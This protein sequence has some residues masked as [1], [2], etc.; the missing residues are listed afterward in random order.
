[1]VRRQRLG[2]SRNI[3]L[4]KR[5]DIVYLQFCVKKLY[6]FPDLKI[7][8][9]AIKVRFA[10]MELEMCQSTEKR[11]AKYGFLINMVN[12]QILTFSQSCH[13]SRSSPG[14]PSDIIFNFSVS[15]EKV[16]SFDNF[17]FR[18][19]CTITIPA[20]H[21]RQCKSSLTNIVA[22]TPFFKW[23][24]NSVRLCGSG[25]QISGYQLI[26]MADFDIFYF[27]QPILS[28]MRLKISH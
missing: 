23:P 9:N 22:M 18:V 3:L 27:R 6:N 11:L 19:D 20:R 4:W 8:P 2:T 13:R 28:P 24:Q 1:M 10:T 21:A 14:L 12:N 5:H 26:F 17:P 7:F 25:S 15:V 16:R